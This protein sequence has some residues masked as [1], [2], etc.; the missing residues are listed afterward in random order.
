MPPLASPI[1]MAPLA[2]MMFLAGAITHQLAGDALVKSGY[3]P[4]SL[5]ST[6]GMSLQIGAFLI[7]ISL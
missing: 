3:G 2:G 5:L 4:W 1:F 6:V 7:L